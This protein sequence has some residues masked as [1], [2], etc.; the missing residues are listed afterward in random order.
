MAGVR[1]K[2][3]TFMVGVRSWADGRIFQDTKAAEGQPRFIDG[4]AEACLPPVL[5]LPFLT[6]PG[7]GLL[8]APTATPACEQVRLSLGPWRVH[9]C[10]PP[11]RPGPRA[12][13]QPAWRPCCLRSPL[14]SEW[15]LSL[16][17]ALSPPSGGHVQEV[18]RA[19]P[20]SLGHRCKPSLVATHVTL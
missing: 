20:L 7:S 9:R 13:E 3:Q 1:A 11:T 14:F 4:E 17:E 12:R 18:G 2:S 6:I 15:P 19:V 10:E 8:S 5:S 16:T